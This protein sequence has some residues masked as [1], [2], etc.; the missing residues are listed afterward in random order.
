[1]TGREYLESAAQMQDGVRRR[2]ADRE[3]LETIRR[4]LTPPNAKSVCPEEILRELSAATE[5]L[6]QDTARLTAREADLRTRLESVADPRYRELLHR[7][8]LLRQDMAS[9][10]EGMHYELR[11]LKKLHRLA[12]EAF[13]AGEGRGGTHP[14]SSDGP[15][16]LSGRA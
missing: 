16:A 14:P 8:Y 10:A 12:V 1:M 7:R 6:A 11:Y 5:A 4:V 3:A 15:P 2:A 13:E 9:I